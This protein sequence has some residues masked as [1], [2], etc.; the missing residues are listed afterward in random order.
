M[1]ASMWSGQNGHSLLVG[2]QNGAATLEDRGSASH[3]VNTLCKHD[4]AG[5]LPRYLLKGG[6]NT[7]IWGACLAQLVEHVILTLR[8]M[9]SSPTLCIEPT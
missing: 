1:L 3:K 6:A 2:G 7:K 5:S 8:V 4:P 9:N